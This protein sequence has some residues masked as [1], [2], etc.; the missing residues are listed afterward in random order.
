MRRRR[1]PSRVALRGRSTPTALRPPHSGIAAALASDGARRQALTL[2]AAPRRH[3]APCAGAGARARRDAARR[4]SRPGAPARALQIAGR[5]E[6]QVGVAEHALERLLAALELCEEDSRTAPRRSSTSP[7]SRFGCRA[8]SRNR[9]PS[10]GA[11]SPSQ[12]A[13]R[14]PAARRRTTCWDRHSRWAG[15][16]PRP[17]SRSSSRTRRSSA[18]TVARMFRPRTVEPPSACSWSAASQRQRRSR[19]ARWL[20]PGAGGRCRPSGL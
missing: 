14:A 8:E 2:D 18:S 11:A 15:G 10:P 6:F 4:G 1:W 3:G 19:S 13:A 16:R 5:V 20:S 17:S 12:P 9:S 7:A